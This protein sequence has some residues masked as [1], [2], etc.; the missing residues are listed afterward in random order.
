LEHDN[1]KAPERA[2]SC[3]MRLVV[4]G[5]D[6]FAEDA[7]SDLYAA[8][9]LVTKKIEQQIRKR[10]SKFKARNHADAAAGK[11]S[12]DQAKEALLNAQLD[13]QAALKQAAQELASYVK[14][15]ILAK[16]GKYVVVQG[17]GDIGVTPLGL[18][19]KPEV[20]AVA[21]GFSEIFNLWLRDSLANQPVQWVDNFNFFRM[22][23]ANPAKYGL[24]NVTTP[25]C[26]VAAISAIT[27]GLV[28]DG[29]SL[30]CNATPGVP[31]N[32]LAAGANAMTWAF[33]D[34]VHPSTGGHKVLSDEFLRLLKSWG[35]I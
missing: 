26:S 9:D 31:F 18:S 10:H 20:R 7:E 12:A 1:T 13:S 27:G 29:K 5:P 11:I 16:G 35:W 21:S 4:P 17:I 8:I 32:G 25:A 24:D 15:S 30:F 23:A 34:S 14:D 6:L 19:Q 22:L 3:S 33:A 28:T 2:F